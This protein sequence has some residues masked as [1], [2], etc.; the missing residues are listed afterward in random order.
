MVPVTSTSQRILLGA[1]KHA[2]DRVEDRSL[3]VEDLRRPD[4]RAVLVDQTDPV[5]TLPTSM[6]AHPSGICSFISSSFERTNVAV[7]PKDSPPTDP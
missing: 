1:G 2:T 3:V 5:M 4:A 7:G 6:P